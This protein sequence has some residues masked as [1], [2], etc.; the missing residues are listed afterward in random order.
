[1]TTNKA[2]FTILL[3][4]GLISSVNAGVQYFLSDFIEQSAKTGIGIVQVEG[5][6]Y[7]KG[8]ISPD[9][10][11]AA[12]GVGLDINIFMPMGSSS[13][14]E[15]KDFQNI[16]LRRLKYDHDDVIGFE[17]GQLKNVTFGYGLLMDN[18][19]SMAGGT[20]V[21]SNDKAGV[22]GYIKLNSIGVKAMSTA[23]EIRAGRVTYDLPSIT[24]FGA[25]IAIGATYV[26]DANGINDGTVQRPIQK[27]MAAD[28]GSA[29]GGEFF[30]VF[31]EY[32]DLTDQGT[33]LSAGFKGSA[34][35]VFR[36]RAE[37]RQLEKGFVPGYF[38]E[39]Y[40]AQSFNFSTDAPTKS[41][42]GFLVA[43]GFDAMNGYIKADAQYENYEDSNILTAALGWQ[44]LNNTVGVINYSVPFQGDS[45]RVMT[46]DILYKTGGAID[47]IASTKR[48]YYEDN[49]F[50]ETISIGTMINL[51]K[52]IPGFPF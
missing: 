41:L 6:S 9:F 11:I 4:F 20:T 13:S 37:Y 12:L 44:E 15:P 18:Y 3:I 49:K 24:L 27:G 16:V 43:A 7:L 2:F 31:T 5:D 29:I 52:L 42:S 23:S 19:D 45:N 39:N 32:A 22:L 21:F 50:N 28:I 38:N 30:T 48:I 33:G 10:N 51:E 17:W 14:N 40:E 1:M 35:G 46:M 36:Y 26:E 25:P 8:T 47:Y 34:S